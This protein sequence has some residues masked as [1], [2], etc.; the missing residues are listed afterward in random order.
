M[1]FDK[2]HANTQRFNLETSV[3]ILSIHTEKKIA[4]ADYA[5]KS[6]LFRSL[7]I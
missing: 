2:H 4:D 3:E 1:T 5:N 7:G 6:I